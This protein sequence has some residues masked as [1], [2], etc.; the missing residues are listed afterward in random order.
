MTRM[1]RVGRQHEIHMLLMRAY[2]K[3][4]YAVF[5]VG[6]IA[7]RMGLKSST[8]LKNIC[9]HLVSLKLGVYIIQ[10]ERGDLFGYEP[11]HQSDFF[12]RVITIN[13]EPVKVSEAFQKSIDAMFG[14][15]FS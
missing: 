8:Y 10:T 9:R 1:S 14:R 12:D 15:T 7:R 11:P 2:H 13:H 6:D 3:D 4:S 5:Y